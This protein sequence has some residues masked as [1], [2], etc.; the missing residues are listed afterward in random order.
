MSNLV[1]HAIQDTPEM[2]DLLTVKF[3]K[4]STEGINIISELK[5]YRRF[6]HPLLN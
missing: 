6:L 4:L 3:T 5:V 2:K 1:F